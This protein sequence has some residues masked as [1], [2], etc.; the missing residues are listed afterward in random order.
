MRA[1]SSCCLLILL[2]GTLAAQPFGRP[3][4]LETVGIDQKLNAQV[5]LDL[6]FADE[7]GRAVQLKEYLNGSKPVVLSLVYY[8]CPMLCNM[9]LNGVLHSMKQMSLELGKDYDV[10]TV[11]FDPKEKPTMAAEK[12][13]AYYAKYGRGDKAGWHFLTGAEKEIRQLADSVG[14]HYAWDERAQQWGHASG[15]MILTPEGKVS[16]YFY[17]VEYPKMTVRLGLVEASNNKIGKLADQMLLFCYA[18]DPQKGQY[19]FIVV[20]ILRLAGILTVIALGSFMFLMLRRERKP[21]LQKI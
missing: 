2:A 9:V 10:L 18:Y 19:G 7:T 4:A 21:A 12:K 20:N 13:A 15:I 17:G 6:T 3:K 1:R 16:R 8:Q 11:S 14:F 5:P